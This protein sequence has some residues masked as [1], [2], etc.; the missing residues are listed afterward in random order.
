MVTRQ[1]SNLRIV[2]SNPAGG[3]SLHFFLSLL[4]FRLY[5]L[6]LLPWV[7]FFSI[8]FVLLCF[9]VYYCIRFTY[10]VVY[11][12]YVRACVRG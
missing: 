6:L 2:G 9:P 5:F 11:R 1:T 8:S 12:A 4:L 10:C 3:V 7:V